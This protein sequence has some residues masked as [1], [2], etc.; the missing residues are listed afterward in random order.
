MKAPTSM[1]FMST[2]HHALPITEKKPAIGLR[3]A[4]NL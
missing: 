1:K 3:P 2:I 4:R